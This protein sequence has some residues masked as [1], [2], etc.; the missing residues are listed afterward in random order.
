MLGT[1]ARLCRTIVLSHMLASSNPDG[2][3]QSDSLLPFQ[4]RTTS[5]TRVNNLFVN[6]GS[7]VPPDLLETMNSV[8]FKSILASI[9]LDS[10]G[11]GGIE[12]VQPGNPSIFPKVS[13]ELPA[14]A[15]SS[16]AEQKGRCLIRLSLLRCK[17]NQS[18]AVRH[19]GVP[20][21]QSQPSQ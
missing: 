7:S 14:K 6:V 8:L 15:R 2:N 19:L 12:T 17:G 4:N 21:F 1:P 5:L 13:R 9:A 10:G 3:A 11:I 16:H 20:L 18:G